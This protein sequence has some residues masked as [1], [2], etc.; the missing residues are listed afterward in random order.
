MVPAAMIFTPGMVL[1][2][3]GIVERSHEL[4]ERPVPFRRCLV[5]D[6]R[7]QTVQGRRP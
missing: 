5:D 1:D 2:A 3:G 7:D 4:L 6:V